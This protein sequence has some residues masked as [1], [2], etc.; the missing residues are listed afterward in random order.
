MKAQV[1][2]FHC[3]LTNKLGQILSSTFNRD[4]IT[5]HGNIPAPLQ[6]LVEG[7]Q[8]LKKGQRRRIAVSAE[9]AFGFYDPGLVVEIRRKMV[10][11]AAELK[12][13]DSVQVEVEESQIRWYK[14]IEVSRDS[15]LLDANHPLAGQDLVFEIEATDVR[16]ATIEELAESNG[17][18]PKTLLH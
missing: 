16:D 3:V 17:A 14:V 4:V 18:G 11:Q 7:L 15:V 1:V 6:G 9:H 8:D 10:P 5:S 12:V 2:S 13:G